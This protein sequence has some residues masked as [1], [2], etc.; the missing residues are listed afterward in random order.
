MAQRGRTIPMGR[1]GR[2]DDI[3]AAVRFLASPEA[4]YVTGQ[5]L[6][7]DGG[8]ITPFPLRRPADA[9]SAQ[10]HRLPEQDRV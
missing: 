10:A 5:A 1:V 8:G 7:V 3:A 9:E 4:G 2:P 6:P